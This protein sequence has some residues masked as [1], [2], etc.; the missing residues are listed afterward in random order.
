MMIGGQF[1]IVHALFVS[2]ICI[3]FTQA[4]FCFVMVIFVSIALLWFVY[5]R[6]CFSND[7]FKQLIS[8]EIDNSAGLVNE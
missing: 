8:H 5:K 1:S 3:F 7:E 2:K 6:Y 4:F